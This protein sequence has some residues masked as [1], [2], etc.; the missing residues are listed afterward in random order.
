MGFRAN[1]LGVII[2]ALIVVI[3]GLTYISDRLFSG[4]TASVEE[5][6]FDLMKAILD[7]A[8]T[9]AGSR[10]L[11]R[12][13]LVADLPVT[14]EAVAAQDRERLLAQYAEMFANQRA[15]HGVDQAQFHIP[16]ATSLLRLQ[17]PDKFGDDLTKFRPMVAAVNRDHAARKGF[18]IARTGPAIFGVAPIKDAAGA[19]IGSFE[20]G[21]DFSGLLDNLKADFGL[22]LGLFIEEEPLRQFASGLDPAV[23]SDQNRVGRFIRFHATNAQLINELA[24]DADISKLTEPQRYTR[25]AQGIPFGV[26]LVP[27]KNAAGES[28]GVMA[29][30]RDFSATRAAAGRSLVW[31]VCL[32]VFAVVLLSGVAIVVIRGFVFRPLSV[33]ES[34]LGALAAGERATLSEDTDRFPREIEALAEHVERIAAGKKDSAS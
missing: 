26:L 2:A 30:A 12:A 31:Q 34:R 21:I 11:A 29:V 5:G 7:N 23:L 1:A 17:A 15:R 28:L 14:K 27:L 13:E 33:I 32:A 9:G 19:H 4:L 10:A 8:L 6:Q 25:D 18:A 24:G 16:P 3:G 22:E 20:F